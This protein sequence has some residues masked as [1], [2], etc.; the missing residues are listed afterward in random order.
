MAGGMEPTRLDLNI[1]VRALSS[2]LGEEHIVKELDKL[3]NI[4][5][6]DDVLNILLK[7]MPTCRVLGET[8]PGQ[9]QEH[10]ERAGGDTDKLMAYYTG[11]DLL[12][13]TAHD[14][15]LAVA[16][17]RRWTEYSALRDHLE[18]FRFGRINREELQSILE[19]HDEAPPTKTLA[20]VMD[21]M[22]DRKDAPGVL[23]GFPRLDDKTNGLRRSRY[24]ILAARPGVGKSDLAL[25]IA[26]NVAIAGGRVYIASIEMDEYE[27]GDRLIK[28]METRQDIARFGDRITLDT[29][30]NVTVAQIAAAVKAGHYD[31]VIV[32]YMQIVHCPG[33]PEHERYARMTVL[34]NQMRAA[35]KSSPAAWLVLSQFS[36][37]VRDEKDRPRLSDLR[38]SGAIEQDAFSV[39]ALWNPNGID[40]ESMDR[41]VQLIILKSR[42]GP[43]AAI[44][45]IFRPSTSG[46]KER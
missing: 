36:R 16:R 4:R 11:E 7:V 12:Y 33:V 23:T 13:I 42:R 18:D 44:N 10:F 15:A 19:D 43:L 17:V 39:M 1:L 32:D 45:L 34:S 21:E 25:K 2:Y 14:V 30:P 27:I 22:Q 31:V 46:W 8:S 9:V 40:H 24:H 20:Q 5:F 6:N 38:E 3:P 41:D 26:R 35:A 29:R 28:S 37:Q